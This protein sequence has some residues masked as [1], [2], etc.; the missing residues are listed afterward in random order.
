MSTPEEETRFAEAFSELGEAAELMVEPPAVAAIHGK[1]RRRR[2][3]R[4]TVAAVAALALVAPASWM[5]QQV[6]N[7][8]EQD[9][10]VVADDS[11]SAIAEETTTPAAAPTTPAETEEA[12]TEDGEQEQPVLPTFDEL[13][14]TEI[15]LPSFMPGNDMVDQACPVDGAVL[16]DGTTGEYMQGEGR[17]GLL[18]VVNAPMTG[19]GGR[20]LPVLFLGCRFGEAAA[21]QAVVLDQS[22]GTGDWYAAAQLIASKP[23]ADSPYD[24]ALAPDYGVLVGVAENYACCD[25]DPDA[26]DYW[27]ERITLDDDFEA[28]RTEVAEGPLPD[29]AI[30]V[31][32]T[33]TDEPGV[34]TVTATIR[35]DG[36]AASDDYHLSACA[37]PNE[38][39]AE[40]EV[41]ECGVDAPVI[42]DMNGLAPGEEHTTSWEVHV[43]PSSEWMDGAY[44]WLDISPNTVTADGI[45]RDQTLADNKATYEFTE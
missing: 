38:I 40:F 2:T 6:A 23:D 37:D 39:S 34:W 19:A 10:P 1:V 14:G 22:E 17:I 45:A 31:E 8:D 15:D 29:L 33:E 16:E 11:T 24:L 28:V 7:A 3:V 21:Y 30:T 20:E 25:M 4:V 12:D 27:V 5:L 41:V 13:V 35:N 42:E 18:E 32:A 9:K 44:L 36:E 26:L 43:V